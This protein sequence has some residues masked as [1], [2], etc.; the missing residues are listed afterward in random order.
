MLHPMEL[1]EHWNQFPQPMVRDFLRGHEGCQHPS[2]IKALEL[3]RT[4]RSVLDVGCGTGVMFEVL[5]LH[6]PDIDY[7][8]VDVTPQFIEEA[9]RRHPAHA[10]QFLVGSLYELPNLGRTFDAVLC[11]HILEHLPDY[12]PAVQEMYD[13]AD[14][15]VILIFYL[16]PRP[17]RWGRKLD[18]K[19]EKGF[20]TH[21]YDLGQFLEYLINGLQPNPSELRVYPHQG[22]SESSLPWGDRENVI[23]EIVR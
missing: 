19:F 11:R 4:M 18:E 22:T 3:L 20:Y 12:I 9:Q 21:T 15:K 23:Y 8:G 10:D 7:T 17:L 14:R 5:Q 1:K 16:P 6:R 2:R 13:R